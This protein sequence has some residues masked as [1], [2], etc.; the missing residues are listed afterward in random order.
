MMENWSIIFVN[1]FQVMWQGVA[2]FLPRILLA[3]IVFVLGWLVAD[4]LGK[5]AAQ[6]VDLLKVDKA[7]S[8]TGIEEPLKRANIRLNSA[9][10]VGGLIRWFFLIVFLL[11]AFEILG[12]T[13]LSVFLKDVVLQ[14]LLHV[15]AAVFIMLIAA[16]L[17]DVLQKVVVASAKAA[18][19]SST[20]FLGGVT[21]WAIWVFA[22]LA[23]LYELGIAGAL[24][25]TLFTAFV[26]M[27][28]IAG[29]LAF[30]L[31][32]KD[33]AARFIEKL[34]QDISEKQ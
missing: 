18:H 33:A 25:Q 15:I 10:F 20:V 14:Y 19:L 24:I 8:K 28:A 2:E 16:V 27:I 6:I 1:S 34:R 22:I 7:L 31:G 12:L 17:A 13:Q 11:A 21:K 5:F 23:A 4:I 26:A 9:A 30:G 3:L 29:G 32:G